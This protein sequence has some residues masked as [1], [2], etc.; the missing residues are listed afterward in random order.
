[1]TAARRRQRGATAL[2]IALLTPIFLILLDFA[3][4]GGRLSE[5]QAQVDAA[6]HAAARAASLQRT[7]TSA[8]SAARTVAADTLPH[9]VGCRTLD[10]AIDT[11]SFHP[12]GVVVV[13]VQCDV[14][15]SDLAWLP[16][17][18]T[19]TVTGTSTSAVDTYRSASP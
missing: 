2:E 10:V 12:G 6:A 17:P 15:L 7:V 8:A 11:A 1:V 3:V 16:L 19:H 18:G 9:A 4:L 5:S 13:N 14:S